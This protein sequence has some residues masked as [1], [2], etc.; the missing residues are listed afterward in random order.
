[1]GLAPKVLRRSFVSWCAIMSRPK[2]RVSS[3]PCSAPPKLRSDPALDPATSSFLDDDDDDDNADGEEEE[4][5]DEVTSGGRLLISMVALARLACE[6]LRMDP[7][8]IE[9]LI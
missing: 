4:E 3:A 1:M 5:L 7:R 6:A 2:P 9:F 8:I